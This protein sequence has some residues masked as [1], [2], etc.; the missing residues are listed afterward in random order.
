MFRTTI[1]MV[2]GI[3][4]ALMGLS[5]LGS[6]PRAAETA[7]DLPT[8][9]ERQKQIQA[10]TDRLVRRMETMIRVLQYNRLDKS[11]EKQLLDQVAGTL[12]GLS[13]EQ[14]TRLIDALE[15][16]GKVKGEARTQELKEAQDRHEQI[17]LGLKGLLARFDAVKSLDQAA[18]RLDKMARDELDQ[19]LQNAQL[20]WEDND[21]PNPKKSEESRRR[22]ERLAG[23]QSFIHRDLT[24]LL[25][26][27]GGLR[28]LLPPEQQE[29]LRKMEAA[30][31]SAQLLD[32][33]MT[34]CRHLRAAG[35]AADRHGAGAR[36]LGCSGSRPAT[37]RIW[38][39]FCAAQTRSWRRCARLGRK[40]NAPLRIRTWCDKAR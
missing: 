12:N 5:L 28:K 20:T 34:A 25:D 13:R 6:A 9:E 22:A 1:G 19:H 24:T 11:A 33:L 30:A 3:F 29:R 26:Q 23:E 15:K 2:S 40:S 4:L 21:R 14:M 37:S 10:E 27:T 36:R 31:K 35:S 16:A 7:P 18:E 17:V 32:N 39:A 8:Q 38:P